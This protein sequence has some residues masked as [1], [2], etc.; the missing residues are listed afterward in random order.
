[1]DSTGNNVIYSNNVSFKIASSDTKSAYIQI[2]KEAKGKTLFEAKQR[3]E[4]IQYSYK[5]I[6]NQLV[7]DNYLLSD[8]KEKFRDQE[9]EITLFLPLGTL[10]KVDKSLAQYDQTDGNYF[11]WNPEMTNAV[12]KVESEKIKCQNCPN[13]GEEI[14]IIEENHKENDST[15]TTTVSVNGEVITVNKTGNKKGL[16][17]NKDGVIIKT[18]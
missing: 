1:M 17:V 11:L 16:S 12:Y 2:E 7:F 5:V 15:I 10:I 18:N 3:A 14:N 13:E 4:K 6:G 8:L 9:I